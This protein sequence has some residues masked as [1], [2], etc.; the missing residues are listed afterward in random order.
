[1][2]GDQHSQLAGVEDLV[3]N[4]DFENPPQSSESESAEAVLKHLHF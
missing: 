4:T 3:E 2:F 1:M